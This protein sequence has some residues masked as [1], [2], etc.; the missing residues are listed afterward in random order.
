[1]LT[2]YSQEVRTWWISGDNKNEALHAM[3]IKFLFI[4]TK[5]LTGITIL[6]KMV[7]RRA[8]IQ[9][10]VTLVLSRMFLRSTVKLQI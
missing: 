6:A 4:K 2:M 9:G 7:K 1:M 5:V 3:P 8:P 10:W